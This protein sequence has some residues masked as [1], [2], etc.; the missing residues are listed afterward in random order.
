MI[1]KATPAD[2]ASLLALHQAVA[3]I[4]GGVIRTLAEVTPQYIDGILQASINNGLILVKEEDGQV[5]GSIHAY[6]PAIRAFR[7]LLSDL[8]IV[9]HPNA[10]GRGLGRDLF[11][12]FLQQVQ[13]G[14]PHILRIELFVRIT[15][16]PAIR[17]YESLGF[18]Q[19]GAQ[20]DKILNAQGQ[21]ETP[22]AMAWYNPNFSK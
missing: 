2:Q 11:T 19:E 12:E 3:A 4:P 8:T 5:V 16:T 20:K 13:Q 1:R 6:T 7:H 22:V 15:N 10:Q 9:V 17:F 21:L 14:F 18:R